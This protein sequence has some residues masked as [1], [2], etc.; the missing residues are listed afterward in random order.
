MFASKVP[1]TCGV[2]E[3]KRVRLEP[4]ALRHVPGL[5]AAATGPRES[6][7]HTSV[8]STAEEMERLVATAVA[9]AE[10]GAGVPFATVDTR[11]GKVVGCTRFANFETV[12][13]PLDG[14]A[15]DVRPHAVE[16]GW[17]W[18]AAEAQRTFVNTEAK[19]LMLTHAF[20]VWGVARVALKT[21]EKNARSRAAIERLGCGLDGISRTWLPGGASRQTAWFSI[22]RE[23]WPANKVRLLARLEGGAL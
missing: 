23:E 17:T 20:E 5:L 3:G 21:S 16:I 22:G 15:I 8:P 19:I 14:K 1:L 11:A 2:L 10:A 4:L 13:V 6:Y 18:L 7:A 9:V 12:Q